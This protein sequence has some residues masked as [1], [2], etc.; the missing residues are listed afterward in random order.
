MKYCVVKDTT[1][2]IDGSDNPIEIML[3]NAQNAGFT[4]V[5]V[6]IL[7]EGEYQTRLENEHKPLQPPTVEERLEALEM[8]MLELALGG[9]D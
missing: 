8:A 3:Q 4:D 5:E 6:E 9:A 1:K 2:V 7:T